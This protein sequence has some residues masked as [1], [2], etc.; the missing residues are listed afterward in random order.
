[1]F[2]LTSKRVERTTEN[3]EELRELVRAGSDRR[4]AKSSRD[5]RVAKSSRDRRVAKSSRDRRVAKSSRDR[6]VAKSSR[7]RQSDR[8]S[9]LSGSLVVDASRSQRSSS[10]YL[11]IVGSTELLSVVGLTGRIRWLYRMRG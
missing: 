9:I 5:R 2:T 1:M 3:R 6:R 10:R 4:V 8:L 11:S 7:D